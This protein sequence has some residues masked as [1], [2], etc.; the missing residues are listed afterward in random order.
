MKNDASLNWKIGILGIYLLVFGVLFIQFPLNGSLPGGVDTWFDLSMFNDYANRLESWFYKTELGTAYFPESNYFSFNNPAFGGALFYIPLKWLGVSDLWAYYGFT[1]ITYALVAF[2]IY[3]LTFFFVRNTF[4]SVYCG[5]AFSCSNFFLST[6]DNPDITLFFMCFFSLYFFLRFIDEENPK[7]MY[8]T[9]VFGGLTVYFSSYAFLFQSIAL[10]IIGLTSLRKIIF[11]RNLFISLLISLAIYTVV[12]YPYAS[13]YILNG[14]VANSWNPGENLFAVATVS[15]NFNDLARFHPNN[16]IYPS[17]KDLGN[18]GW[19]HNTRSAGIGIG[20]YAL[21]VL[22][23]VKMKMK[24]LPLYVLFLLFLVIALGP[25]IYVKN[26]IIEMPMMFLYKNLNLNEYFRISVRAYFMSVTVIVCLA[27]VGLNFLFKSS[28]RSIALGLMAF[29]LAENIPASLDHYQ[30]EQL[31]KAP[32]GYLEFLNKQ[33][34]S[35]IA[36][37]PSSFFSGFHPN[38]PAKCSDTNLNFAEYEVTRDYRYMYWQTK[39]KHNIINGFSGFIP[40]SRI[41]NQAYMEFIER[42]NN[43]HNLVQNNGLDYLI[44]HKQ[45]LLNCEQKDGVLTWLKS[46]NQLEITLENDAICIFQPLNRST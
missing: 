26:T 41:Q 45:L 17:M 32:T 3:R 12:I 10:L 13:I 29:I 21:A 35:T 38:I 4:I 2:S 25:S 30:S 11:Q 36:N 27:G 46:S 22:G 44:Y 16:L 23:I 40:Y 1:V 7:Y 28:Y 14:S 6:I 39:H 5:L 24:G 9:G 34:L 15:L 19:L 42:E 8:Y 20:L 18:T 31:M 43:L 37:Y 33:P